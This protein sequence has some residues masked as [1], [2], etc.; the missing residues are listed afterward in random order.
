MMHLDFETRSRVDIG[1]GLAN[2]N[3]QAQPLCLAYG[4][5]LW[6]MNDPAPKDLFDHISSGG[7]VHG[8]NVMFEWRHWNTAT[9]WPTLPLEQCFDTMAQAAVCNLPQSLKECARVL[10]QEQQKDSK[11]TRLINL[12]S[13]PDHT[14][15]FCEDPA[16]LDQLNQYCL[17]D[18][19]T[20]SQIAA[21][22]PPLSDYERKVWLHTQ[23][24]NINGLPIDVEGCR[25]IQNVV[26]TE[27]ERLSQRIKVATKY[28]V[29]SANQVEKL[30]S[31]FARNGL[32]IPDLSAETLDALDTKGLPPHVCEVV[33]IRRCAAKS[34]V[35]KIGKMIELSHNGRI[36]DLL[37]YHGASTGRFSSKGGFNAQNLPRPRVTSGEGYIDSL[38]TILRTG[39]HE[40][41]RMVLDDEVMDAAVDVVRRLVCAPEGH[42]F[43]DADYSSIENRVSA[44]IAGQDDRVEMFAK[45]LDEYKVFATSMYG[46]EYAGV[47]KQMRQVAKSA[48]LGCMFGQGAAGLVKYATVFKVTLSHEDAQKL[49]DSYRR[50][51]R[52]V[53][54]MW[55][56]LGDASI[57]AV[58]TPNVALQVGKVRLV[59]DGRFLK[60][61]L[62]SNRILYWFAPTVIKGRYG[63]VVQYTDA[64]YGRKE[65]IGSSIFQ[66]AVQATARDLLVHGSMNL[67]DAGYKVVLLVHDEILSE[68]PTNSGDDQEYMRLMCSAPAWASDLPIAAEAWRARRYKK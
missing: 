12:L 61:R 2:Y 26:D 68:V 13:K 47:T 31:W 5:N 25:K 62:P 7:S 1:A 36:H 30:Q 48:V 18:V 39:D 6:A 29:D 46:V 38:L 53:Q 50:Q 56:Q 66:S 34:S 57:S 23:Q 21:Q 9:G 35:A 14:G 28:E 32:T 45:G 63:P 42:E 52:K 40:F 54:Q 55:K 67:M 33:E 49:V 11:G 43:L 17:Q 59:C 4:E 64:K 15:R 19:R 44:W 51:Y 58:R 41:S 37:A 27:I 8:W 3:T 24:I 16:Y 60:L 20:E 10:G 22:L 65:L